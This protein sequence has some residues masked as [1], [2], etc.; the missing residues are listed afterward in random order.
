MRIKNKLILSVFVVFIILLSACTKNEVSTRL[1]KN[2][3]VKDILKK[4]INLNTNDKIDNKDD[5]KK[6]EDFNKKEDINN[7]ENEEDNEF[8]TL[9]PQNDFTKLSGD[10]VF[11]SVYSLMVEP[12]EYVGQEFKMRG[13]YY[14]SLYEPTGE[15]YHYIVLEDALACCSTGIEFIWGDGTHKYPDEYPQNDQIIEICGKF[16]TYKEDGDDRIYF[17]INN[18]S[19]KVVE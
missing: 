17:R 6:D 4:Q 9:N 15:Y 5:V 11:A 14:G 18:A 8:L 10:L 13:K 1:E 12:Q 3:T 7:N 2:N 19:L 16:E